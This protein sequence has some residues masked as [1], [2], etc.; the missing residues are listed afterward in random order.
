MSD[1]SATLDL[2]FEVGN[3][4][5]QTFGVQ[6]ATGFFHSFSGWVIF[7]FAFFGLLAVHGL[8]MAVSRWRGRRVGGTP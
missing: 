1:A 8:L 2:R 4:I 5:G 7:V 3:V 6:Y